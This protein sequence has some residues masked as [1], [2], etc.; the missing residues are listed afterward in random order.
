MLVASSHPKLSSM[1][2]TSLANL[3]S[4][5]RVTLEDLSIHSNLTMI[6]YHGR[7]QAVSVTSVTSHWFRGIQYR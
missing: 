7:L 2:Q 6:D 5:L 3:C 1:L 4:M